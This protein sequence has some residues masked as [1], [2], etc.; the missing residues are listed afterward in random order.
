MD[1]RSVEDFC[2]RKW[3][4]NLLNKATGQFPVF[5]VDEPDFRAV[6]NYTQQNDQKLHEKNISIHTHQKAKLRPTMNEVPIGV[7]RVRFG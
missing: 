3:I 4:A 2:G 7:Y 6:R 1:D 5:I